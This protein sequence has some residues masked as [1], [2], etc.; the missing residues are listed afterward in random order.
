MNL[1]PL[2][3]AIGIMECWDGAPWENYKFQNNNY[4]QRGVRVTQ[5]NF[6]RLREKMTGKVINCQV[7]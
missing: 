4:K 3:S 5:T 6:K 1:A 7:S 2:R